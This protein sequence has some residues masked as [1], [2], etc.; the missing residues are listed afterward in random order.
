MGVIL[1]CTDALNWYA[2]L[3]QSDAANLASGLG[4]LQA[5]SETLFLPYLGGERTPHNDATA[6]GAFLGLGHATD[7]TA[8]ARAVLEGVSY[9]FADCHDALRSTGTRIESLVAVGGGSKS[10]YWLELLA[11]VLGTPI[12]VP[13]AGD[14]GGAFGAARL[15]QM[16]ATGG[17]PELATPPRTAR[18]IEP[19]NGLRDAFAQGHTR[20]KRSYKVLKEAL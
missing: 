12:D 14:F 7:R 19:Q 9:A 18:T 3:V 15:A 1:A 6:R 20:Y 8:G 16:A 2:Q 4:A 13:E 17:G 11:T 5:P 10:D